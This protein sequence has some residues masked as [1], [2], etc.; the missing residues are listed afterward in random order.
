MKFIMN[1][2]QA[3]NQ[4]LEALIVASKGIGGSQMNL[5][6]RYRLG[7]LVYVHKIM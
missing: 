7:Y 6:T 5:L 1:I 4:S 3:L 2:H